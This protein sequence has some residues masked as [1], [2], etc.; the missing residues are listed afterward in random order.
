MEKQQ[1]Y[2][3]ALIALASLGIAAGAT[4]AAYQNILHVS[5]QDPISSLPGGRA[6]PDAAMYAALVSLFREVRL[7]PAEV[8]AVMTPFDHQLQGISYSDDPLLSIATLRKGDRQRN[9]HVGEKLRDH[10]D[11]TLTRIASDYVNITSYGKTLS[12]ALKKY[13]K[14]SAEPTP[15]AAVKKQ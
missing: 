4:F 10:P 2:R 1:S 14:N 12:L 9:Y 8:S 15:N 5:R 11:A 7:P 6:A 13:R 3:A